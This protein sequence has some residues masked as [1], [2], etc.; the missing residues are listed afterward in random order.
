MIKSITA[1]TYEL[2][3]VKI[4]LQEIQSQ[5]KDFHLCKNTV[6]IIMC[7][8]EFIEAGV[9]KAISDNLPFPTAGTTTM[10]QAVRN[11][12]G[13][14]ML[15]L[16]I[17]TSDDAN[18]SVGFTDNISKDILGSTKSSF[19]SAKS[20]LNDDIK[21]AII[22]PPLILENSGDQYVE[23]FEKLC[24]N[25]PIF[26]T[27]AID[28]SLTYEKSASIANGETDHTKMSFILASGNINPRFFIATISKNKLMPYSGEI[29]ESHG[30]I[31]NKI[32]DLPAAKYFETIG[33]AKDNVINEGVQFVPFILDQKK[34]ENYDNVPVVRAL[35]V[36][37]ENGA[38]ICRGDMD[39]NSIFTLSTFDSTDVLE[40]TSELIDIINKE[41]SSAVIMFSCMVRRMSFGVEPLVEAN[42]FVERMKPDVPFMM[43]YSGGEI[44][45]TSSTKN[46]AVN[47]FHNYSLIV[48]VL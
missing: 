36:F 30:N 40:T 5:I 7:D 22:F 46:N 34:K 37:D 18:F 19:E 23:T 35:V 3:N 12:A 15:T 29:T 31:V 45:P 47:R 14:L 1:F 6:G 8:P 20:K 25:T 33:L 42:R 2:D 43:A 26:G 32:N 16:M 44:C 13:M 38:G 9:L 4:A 24:P 27:L 41:E 28:D 21:L 10:S 11:E 48:C 17:L 39:Q